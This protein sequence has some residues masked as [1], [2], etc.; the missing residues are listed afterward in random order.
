MTDRIP[1]ESELARLAA[2]YDTCN[3]E[4]LLAMNPDELTQVAR[5]AL[6][7]QLNIRNLE[8]GLPEP[9]EDPVPSLEIFV[10]EGKTILEAE[11]AANILRTYSI[12]AAASFVPDQPSARK[13]RV[14]VASADAERAL[15]ILNDKPVEEVAKELLK[16]LEA[17]NFVPPTCPECSSERTVL[18][19][20]DPDNETNQWLCESCD[21]QW[22]EDPNSA[23]VRN[24]NSAPPNLSLAAGGTDSHQAEQAKDRKRLRWNRL[25]MVIGSVAMVY[26]VLRGWSDSLTPLQWFGLSLVVVFDVLWIVARWQLGPSF[27][28]KAEAHKLVTEGIYARIQNPIYI[29][30]G[31]TAVGT[32]LFLNWP[33]AALLAIAFLVPTQMARVRRER[34]ILTEAFGEE[35]EAYRRRTWI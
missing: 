5:Q 31:L 25:S 9:E 1:L 17:S 33:W 6:E 14:T 26:I 7:V 29:F 32:F 20:T 24:F 4:T 19:S 10:W 35:Y 28:G 2:L 12:P 22:S 21:H 3:D 8:R 13:F 11:M 15:G 30:G 23:P 34:K 16:E 27:T 18:I